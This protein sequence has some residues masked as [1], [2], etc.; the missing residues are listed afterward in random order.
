MLAIISPSFCILFIIN[1]TFYTL[2][3]NTQIWG[4]EEAGLR[5]LRYEHVSQSCR[6]QGWE[7]R[8]P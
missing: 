8:F 5:T 3:T 2:L 4:L 1:D 7:V 6:G